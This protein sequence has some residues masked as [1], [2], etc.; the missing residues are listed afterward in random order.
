MIAELDELRFPGGVLRR[1]LYVGIVSAITAAQARVN[2]SA[3]GAPTG[4]HFEAHRYG[5]GEVGEFVLIEGQL[6]LVLGRIVEVRLP[7]SE[8]RVMSG[9]HGGTH[10]GDVVGVLQFLGTVHT[11]SLHVNPGI[12]AYPRLGDRVYAAPHQFV[13]K[14]PELMERIVP[15]TAAVALKVG[16]VG[17]GGG[18][19]LVRPER[20]FGRHCAVLGATGGGKSW[21]VA[22]LLEQCLSYPSKVILLDATGEYRS[23]HQAGVTH[24]RLGPQLHADEPAEESSL[25]ANCFHEGD[26]IALFEPSGKVQGPKLREAILALR[27]VAEQPSLMDARGGFTKALQKKKPFLEVQKRLAEAGRLED[28]RTPFDVSKLSHQVLEECVWPTQRDDIKSWGDYTDS[29][30]SY[31]LP[32]VARILSI[33]SADSF[34]PVFRSKAEGGVRNS[35]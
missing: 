28:P 11:D 17:G 6:N 15:Q 30:K 8:R 12:D 33:V 22:M 29:D 25:P 26:F 14:I 5:R 1:E 35:V 23:L 34:A 27:V 4:S 32:L 20:L 13:S 16:H 19:V 10:L 21:T 31:C 18:P 7:E 24:V 9:E 2:L 3:A